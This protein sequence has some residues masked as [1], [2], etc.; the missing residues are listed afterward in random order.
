[1][2]SDPL[3]VSLAGVA[4]AAAALAIVEFSNAKRKRLKLLEG[5]VVS[6]RDGTGYT[7]AKVTGIDGRV[8]YLKGFIEH[9]ATRS[10][11][12]EFQ[13]WALHDPLAQERA[14]RKTELRDLELKLIFRQVDRQASLEI[15]V[16]R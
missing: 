1:M 3:I 8:I 16:A 12:G 7:V 4:G 13:R 10:S 15:P 6:A 2:S 9:R 11:D 5:D 14:V